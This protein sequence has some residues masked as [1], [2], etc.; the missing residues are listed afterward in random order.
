MR[1]K[2]AS[3][4]FQSG[5]AGMGEGALRRGCLTLDNVIAEGNYNRSMC[6]ESK[7]C[8][9]VSTEHDPSMQEGVVEPRVLP[10][11]PWLLLNPRLLGPICWAGPFRCFWAGHCCLRETTGLPPIAC[12]RATTVLKL[13]PVSAG[14]QNAHPLIILAQLHSTIR[15]CLAGRVSLLPAT[16]TCLSQLRR[17]T[18]VPLRQI[19]L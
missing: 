10:P 8:G 3:T 5:P 9:A 13:N 15:A 17:N 18:V 16:Y 2:E 12:V 19:V 4:L 11:L 6:Q 7:R 14:T 1:A